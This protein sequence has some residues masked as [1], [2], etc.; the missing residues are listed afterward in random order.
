MLP[1][2][3][4]TAG[5]DLAACSMCPC[6]LEMLVSCCADLRLHPPS[7]PGTIGA[8]YKA[9]FRSLQYNLKDPINPQLRA[10]VLTGELQPARLIRMEPAE[11]ASRE[12]ARWCKQREEEHD[13]ELVLD[14][15]AAAKFST[16]AAA[17]LRAERLRK[18]EA[19][20]PP[21]AAAPVAANGSG[22]GAGG[23]VQEHAALD[24]EAQVSPLP[25]ASGLAVQRVCSWV[26]Y[27]T[28]A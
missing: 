9:K 14:A 6:G 15:E 2:S 25:A 11:L 27:G 7:A 18:R 1:A 19:T 8:Q 12:L 28:G 22:A 16:A 4:L 23:E 26:L 3:S 10:R 21:A 24:H 13:K 5:H 20:P 17:A